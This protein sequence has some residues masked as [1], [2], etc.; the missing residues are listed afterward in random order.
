M[1]WG[2]FAD[3]MIGITLREQKVVPFNYDGVENYF[4]YV[5]P[6]ESGKS[7]QLYRT[8]VADPKNWE[9]LSLS[10]LPSDDVRLSQITEYNGSLYVPATD[11]TLYTSADGLSWSAVVGAPSVRYVFGEV[12]EGANQPSALATVVDKDGTLAFYAMNKSREWLAGGVVPAQ[13]P[14]TG[15]GNI[16]YEAMYHAY[17]LVG[18]GRDKDNQLTNTSWATMDG[19]S[20]ALMGSEAQSGFSKREG[21]MLAGY[22][23]KFFMIGG[24]DASGKALKDIHTSIDNGITWSLMDT[25]VVLPSDYEARGFSS[26]T[27]DKQNYVNIFGG[28]TS[29]GS[30]ELNQLWRGRINRLV[31]KP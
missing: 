4:M 27:V 9:F 30:D 12:K 11:G 8:P 21:V 18:G 3:P 29:P 20:W 31:P 23:E 25:M 1:I 26:I 10:G 13:F 15:F 22:D 24:L 14:L 5:N 2:K 28:K 16:Q 17:L 19:K 6:V 7:Y